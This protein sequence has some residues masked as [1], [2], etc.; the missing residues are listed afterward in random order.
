MN[1]EV[2][3]TDRSSARFLAGVGA[4]LFWDGHEYGCHVENLSR[5]GALLAGELPPAAGPRVRVILTSTTGDLR[6]ESEARVLR[7]TTDEAATRIGVEFEAME[8]DAR[9]TLELLISRVVEG[10]APAALEALPIDAT[11]EQI[12]DALNGTA[13]VHRASLATRCV[14][15]MREILLHDTDPSVLDGLARNPTLTPPELR[16]LLGKNQLL[17]RT[18][19]TLSRDGRFRGLEELRI[20][21]ACHPN[22]LLT[23]AEG[24]FYTLTTDGRKRAL[25]QPGLKPLLR[26]R[27]ARGRG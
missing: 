5:T 10:R 22:A 16:N 21:I 3:S 6:F 23:T 26:A 19:E 18:L 9:E 13:I 25:R 15:R 2:E 20:L 24:L 11:P 7:I 12:R 27:L 4:S 14:P 17:P 8:P 1:R